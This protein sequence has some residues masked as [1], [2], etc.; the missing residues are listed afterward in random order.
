VGVGKSKSF[1]S[2]LE[3][4]GKP[5]YWVITRIPFD[6]KRAWGTGARIKVKGTINGYAFRTSLFPSREGGHVLL[7]N[8]KMQ[9]GAGVGP[10]EVAKFL[11]EPDTEIRTAAIPPELKRELGEDKALRRWFDRLNYSTRKWINDWITDVKNPD[12]R[13]RRAEQIA[14]RLMLTMDAE[15]ELPPLLRVAFARNPKAAEGWERMSTSRRRGHLMGI[16]YYRTPEARARRLEKVLEDAQ[17]VAETRRR[18]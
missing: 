2:V 3:R 16:F 10:G 17:R 7:V 8:K 15:S 4:A 13:V 18:M 9:A 11:L 1:R 6:A 5:L 14:E 12:A